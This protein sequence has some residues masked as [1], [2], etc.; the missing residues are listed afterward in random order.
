M[1]PTFD[2]LAVWAEQ[3]LVRIHTTDGR[4][5]PEKCTCGVC[6]LAQAAADHFSTL[7]ADPGSGTTA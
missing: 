7:A 2:E 6:R 4:Y 5:D 3:R 1:E